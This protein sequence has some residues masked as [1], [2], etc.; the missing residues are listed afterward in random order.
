MAEEPPPNSFNTTSERGGW[1]A[2]NR[3]NHMADLGRLDAER[4]PDLAPAPPRQLLGK[5]DCG[6]LLV[7]RSPLRQS[8]RRH[9]PFLCNLPPDLID[10]ELGGKSVSQGDL[11][12][13]LPAFEHLLN[14]LPEFPVAEESGFLQ[15]LDFPSRAALRHETPKRAAARARLAALLRQAAA[16]PKSLKKTR[17]TK[18]ARERRLLA[19]VQRARVKARRSRVSGDE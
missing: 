4:R 14:P 19:K 6:L 13:D 17:P 7:A 9:A 2:I 10:F 18:A 8:L 12:G 15:L 1:R 3:A 16:R 11:V 5:I